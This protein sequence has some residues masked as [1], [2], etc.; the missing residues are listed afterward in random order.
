LSETGTQDARLRAGRACLFVLA[1]DRHVGEW[2]FALDRWSQ[3]PAPDWHEVAR[4]VAAIAA[5]AEAT[6]LR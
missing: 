6:E 2:K 3:D 1:M 5:G 4:V